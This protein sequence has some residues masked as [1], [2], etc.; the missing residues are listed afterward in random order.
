V[1]GFR[2]HKDGQ[3]I[4]SLLLG[5]FDPDGRLQHVGV[6]ASFSARRRGEL[7]GELAPLV[8]DDLAAHPWGE[9]ADAE[10]HATGRMPG[11]PSRWQ[12]ARPKDV[13]WVPLRLALV[14]EVKYGSTLNG[15]FREVTNLLRWRPDKLPEQCTFDQLDEPEPVGVDEVL[16]AKG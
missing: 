15:R 10:A 8:L 2:W 9:W 14:A 13:S 7:V 4:G 11:A 1:A 16:S 12:G 3:G 5:L 6:A